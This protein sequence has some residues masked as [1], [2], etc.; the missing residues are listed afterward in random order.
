M[1]EL[2]K[3]TLLILS[4]VL[5]VFLISCSDDNDDSNPVNTNESEYTGTYEMGFSTFTGGEYIDSLGVNATISES[6]GI[7]TGEAD[8]RFKNITDNV[9]TTITINGGTITGAIQGSE[10]TV[11]ITGLVTSNTF[12]FQG[13][14]V[15][16]NEI[17][18]EGTVV[19]SDGN[20]TFTYPSLRLIKNLE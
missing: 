4:L 17:I 1:E 16:G 9:T 12:S 5:S 13:T 18:F 11:T 19:I 3:K 7:L 20:N 6:N 10:I 2:M 14:K 15:A 8:Y